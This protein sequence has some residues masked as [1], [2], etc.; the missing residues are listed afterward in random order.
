MVN[1]SPDF[2]DQGTDMRMSRSH[3][4]HLRCCC[5]GMSVVPDLWT[6]ARQAP[7]SVG[8]SRQEYL[9][10]LPCPPPED[11]PHPGI[12]PWSPALQADCLPLSRRGSLSA[13]LWIVLSRS[14]CITAPWVVCRTRAIH[15]WEPL[16]DDPAHGQTPVMSLILVTTGTETRV[17]VCV[18]DE[19][20]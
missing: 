1:T 16:S 9:G 10:G 18:F 11:L 12:E 17:C 5:L 14:K 6:G 13:Q 8:F 2:P 7:L 20:A 3:T 4:A 19:P 15:T